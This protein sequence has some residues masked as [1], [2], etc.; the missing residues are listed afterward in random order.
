MWE[1]ASAVD[2]RQAHPAQAAEPMI[3]LIAW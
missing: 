2:Q 3:A 1:A